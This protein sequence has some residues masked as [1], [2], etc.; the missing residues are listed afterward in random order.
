MT[1]T[2][3]VELVS[4]RQGSPRELAWGFVQE[5]IEVIIEALNH[6]EE[7]RIRG[8]GRLHWAKVKGRSISDFC[9]GQT[10]IPDGWK[11]KFTPATQF[12]SR[13]TDSDS[14]E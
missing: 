8:L 11:L 9:G 3:I 10:I 2:E 1:L 7:I 5:T 6:G 14:N 13:R 4:R 12:K